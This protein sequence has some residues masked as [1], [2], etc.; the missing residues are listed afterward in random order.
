PQ[1]GKTHNGKYAAFLAS[2]YATKDINN[3]DNKTAL[4]VYDLESNNGTPIAKIEVPNGKGGLSSPTLVDKDLDGTVDIAYAG[5]RGGSMYRF[6]LSGNNPTSW[7]AR[8]IFS[9][10]KPITSA[11]AISQLK[12]KRVV[13]FGTGSD[14]SEEDVDSKEIQHVYGIFD[15]DTDTGTAQ[16]GQGKGLLEQKLEKDKDGKTLFLSDYKRSDGSGDKGWV[17]KLEAGQ[18]V[19]VKPTVVLR[20]A[21]VTI[22]K[23]TGNDK[24][25]AET[26]I[27]GINTADG[28]KLTK[29]S[30]RPIVPADNT[31]VAQ[32]SGHK[33]TAKGKSIPIGCMEKNNG[34]VCPNGYV[35]DK[36][37]NVRYL[38]EKKTDGFSTTA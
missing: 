21:F 17:V 12:D 10:N 33:Q 25:G 34:I 32:Y 31:A 28:G 6:D 4:Y 1:I 19:T 13:I 7:S 23:Y 18:R 3:G 16:D 38:D 9:G 11:P 24:C 36:P 35:Y 14:L 5:D 30:A 8:A 22:H 2:G 20:T 15:N 37:V 27:L 29:K 26:A